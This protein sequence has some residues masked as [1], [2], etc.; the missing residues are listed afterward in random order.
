VL[1]GALLAGAAAGQ[2]LAVPA[3]AGEGT[4]AGASRLRVKSCPRGDAPIALRFELAADGSWDADAPVALEGTSSTRLTWNQFYQHF[5][6]RTRL[7]LSG[8]SLA[9]LQADLAARTSALCGES[10]SIGALAVSDATLVLNKRW[11]R[12]KLR[13][14]A[15]A[16]AA[17]AAGPRRLQFRAVATGTWLADE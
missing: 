1:F 16:A 2:S 3:P 4:L 6:A 10:V 5:R 12:A 14:R 15:S 9:V 7:G 17:L 13:L 11:T 8:A